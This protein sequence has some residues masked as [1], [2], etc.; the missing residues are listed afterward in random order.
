MAK[1]R[2]RAGKHKGYL[3]DS[4]GARA[5][6]GHPLKYSGSN[7]PASLHTHARTHTSTE[8]ETKK[9]GASI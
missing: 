6:Q 4:P 1:A 5:G 8:G 2:T 3:H 7:K 9:R